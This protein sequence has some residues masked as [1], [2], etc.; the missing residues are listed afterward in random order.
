M[1]V[2]GELPVEC[3]DNFERM[4][5][6]IDSGDLPCTRGFSVGRHVARTPIEASM[7]DHTMSIVL[8]AGLTISAFLC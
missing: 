3:S 6:R 2:G 1:G 4:L 8:I 5:R 7:W